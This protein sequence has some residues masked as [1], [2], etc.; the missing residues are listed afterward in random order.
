MVPEV[1]CES[2]TSVS[3]IVRKEEIVAFWYTTEFHPAVLYIIGSMQLL[4]SHPDFFTAV[5]MKDLLLFLFPSETEP[6]RVRLHEAAPCK[7]SQARSLQ[8][9]RRISTGQRRDPGLAW[10][11]CSHQNT[12]AT[13]GQ[14]SLAILFVHPIPDL[15]IALPCSARVNHSVPATALELCAACVLQPLPRGA[16]G[17]AWLPADQQTPWAG[18]SGLPLRG[19][20]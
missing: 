10:K 13:L 7:G 12:V 3:R 15:C 18:G 16:S 20:R 4:A 8:T 17:P 9:N 19:M 11:L 14:Y 6:S 1:L 2:W 5:S